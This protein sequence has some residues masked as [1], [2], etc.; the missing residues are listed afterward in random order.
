MRDMKY[1]KRCRSARVKYVMKQFGGKRECMIYYDRQ[2][3]HHAATSRLS[4][5]FPSAVPRGCFLGQCS[6]PIDESARNCPERL[7]S[8]TRKLCGCRN[9]IDRAVYTSVN[10]SLRL[11]AR[12]PAR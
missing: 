7:L 10:F 5:R 11:M 12:T 4:D 8:R 9:M 2:P 6:R 1:M 3:A